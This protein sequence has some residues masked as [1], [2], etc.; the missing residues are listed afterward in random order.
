MFFAVNFSQSP[1]SIKENG[2][3]KKIL[4]DLNALGYNAPHHS[5]LIYYDAY[6]AMRAFQGETI[7]NENLD[8]LTKDAILE[9]AKRR[10]KKKHDK[11]MENTARV[12]M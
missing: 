6:L 3:E 8:N 7:L 12:G 5:E 2:I 9:D 10:F 1:Q 4:S 11:Y